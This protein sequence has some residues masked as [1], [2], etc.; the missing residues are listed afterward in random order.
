MDTPLSEVLDVVTVGDVVNALGT[1]LI[2]MA[3][4]FV[5]LLILGAVGWLIWRWRQE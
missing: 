4:G 1:F 5:A 3:M 2:G